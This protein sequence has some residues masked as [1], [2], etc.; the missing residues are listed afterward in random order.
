MAMTNAMPWHDNLTSN[1]NALMLDYEFDHRCFQSQHT[2]SFSGQLGN[3]HAQTA[4]RYKPLRFQSSNRFLRGRLR[5]QFLKV[6]IN[7]RGDYTA[8]N[9]EYGA[10]DVTLIA[11]PIEVI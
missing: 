1:E 11:R 2:V 8:E 10:I 3:T 4:R 6:L 9:T 7:E 5:E